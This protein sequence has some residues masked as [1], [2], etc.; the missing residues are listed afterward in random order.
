MNRRTFVAAVAAG[1]AGGLAGCLSS[2]DDD[3]EFRGEYTGDPTTQ[4]EEGCHTGEIFEDQFKLAGGLA[5]ELAG[6]SSV[7]WLLDIEDGNELIINITTRAPRG[8]TPRLPTVEFI[9]PNG[10]VLLNRSD[11]DS[12]YSITLE[13]TGEYVLRV[14]SR[15]LIDSHWW[16]MKVYW[17]PYEECQ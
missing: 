15:E 14:H 4:F 3:A 17:D 8:T 1:G 5:S 11:S 10:D 12:S 6:T 13:S 16:V 7:E 2:S 9:A